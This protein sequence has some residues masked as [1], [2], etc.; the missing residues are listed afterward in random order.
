M[1]MDDELPGGGFNFSFNKR[2]YGRCIAP[3]TSGANGECDACVSRGENA[4]AVLDAETCYVSS[5]RNLTLRSSRDNVVSAIRMEVQRLQA[6]N[7]FRSD[8][9]DL[10]NK[11]KGLHL[12]DKQFYCYKGDSR[13]A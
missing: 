1:F 2:V 4:L 6:C 5:C 11:R 12:L 3:G 9:P 13:K 7:G 8:D 10:A